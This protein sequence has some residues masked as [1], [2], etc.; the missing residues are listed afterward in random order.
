[1]RGR[2]VDGEDEKFI[3]SM[4]EMLLR[5]SV[6]ISPKMTEWQKRMPKNPEQLDTIEPHIRDACQCGAGTLKST[7]ELAGKRVSGQIDGGCTKIRRKLRK[8]SPE[9]KN[10]ANEA[11]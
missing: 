10:T 4:M 11:P 5:F 7:G 8:S 9:P 6:E 1:M 2:A 3:R